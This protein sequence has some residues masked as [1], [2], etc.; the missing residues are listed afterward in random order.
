MNPAIGSFLLSGD[1]SKVAATVAK[2]KF[3]GVDLVANII[4]MV[5]GSTLHLISFYNSSQYVLH[6]GR[7]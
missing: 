7:F 1:L 5:S 4:A 3:I 2:S 6:Q